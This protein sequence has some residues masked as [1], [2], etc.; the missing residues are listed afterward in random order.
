MLPKD[1]QDLKDYKEN[2][3]EA[4]N[5]IDWETICVYLR[6]LA[7]KEIG[8]GCG[9]NAPHREWH[10]AKGEAFREVV[11]LKDIVEGDL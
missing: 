4:L 5:G 8:L 7:E 3:L 9:M 1:P 11:R 2:L 6:A 10:L